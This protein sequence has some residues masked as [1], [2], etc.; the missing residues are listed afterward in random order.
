MPRSVLDAVVAHLQR[1]ANFGGYES[2]DQAASAVNE[3]YSAI[4]RILGAQTRNVAIV[5]NAT[6]AFSQALSAF[7]FRPGEAI[8]TS[9]RIPASSS[10][11]KL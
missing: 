2:A 1:E 5:E 3:A 8:V 10:P 4:A 9:R 6:V 7:D 11:S